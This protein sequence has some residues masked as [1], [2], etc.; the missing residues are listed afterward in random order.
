MMS[1][2]TARD[3]AGAVLD[4]LAG[5]AAVVDVGCGPGTITVGLAEAIAPG[6]TVVGV[7]AE[8][9]QVVA[10]RS[11]AAHSAGNAWFAVGRTAAQAGRWRPGLRW[12]LRGRAERAGFAVDEVHGRQRVDLGYAELADYVGR[13]PADAVTGWADDRPATELATLTGSLEGGPPVVVNER[14]LGPNAGRR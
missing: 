14:H 2:R 11:A 9:S 10:A 7:D 4:R 5:M 13:R 8:L 3:R 12:R 1:S 6:G